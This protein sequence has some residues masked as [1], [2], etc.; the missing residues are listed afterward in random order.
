[1]EKMGIF[2][3]YSLRWY[4]GETEKPETTMDNQVFIRDDNLGSVEI[5]YLHDD[6][7][8]SP[9]HVFSKLVLD[10]K[11]RL[12]TVEPKTKWMRNSDSASKGIPF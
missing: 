6:W 9:F 3:D 4:W 5:N 8:F 12:V 11:T 2:Y 7:S 10:I 1:M